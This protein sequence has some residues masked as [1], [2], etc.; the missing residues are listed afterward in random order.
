MILKFKCLLIL[1]YN[2]YYLM[3]GLCTRNASLNLGETKC[4]ASLSYKSNNIIILNDRCDS[5]TF[6][7]KAV[8]HL[9]VKY[10]N[11]KAY[12]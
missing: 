7:Q 1:K 6:S 5:T 10:N 11:R 2:W 8:I 3:I 4:Y 12:T 9:E